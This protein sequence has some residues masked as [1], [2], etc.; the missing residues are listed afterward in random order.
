[1][2]APAL[3]LAPKKFDFFFLLV[4]HHSK[5]TKIKGSTA[6][7]FTPHERLVPDVFDTIVLIFLFTVHARSLQQNKVLRACFNRAAKIERMSLFSWVKP[8]VKS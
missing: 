7:E 6:L 2:F 1:M 3:I 5:Q 8:E 4:Q